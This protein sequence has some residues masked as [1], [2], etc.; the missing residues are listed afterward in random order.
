MN[1]LILWEGQRCD[2]E[3]RDLIRI[4]SRSLSCSIGE[5]LIDDEENHSYCRPMVYEQPSSQIPLFIILAFILFCCG[6]LFL[7]GRK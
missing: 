5:I 2:R 7:C 4:I 3:C 1:Q 6:C